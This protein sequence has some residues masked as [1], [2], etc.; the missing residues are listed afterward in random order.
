MAFTALFL[1]HTCHVP[2]E[3]LFESSVQTELHFLRCAGQQTTVYLP[4][5]QFVPVKRARVD[6]NAAPLDPSKARQF[7][8][9]LSRFEFN[10]LPNPHYKA[11]RF[12][13]KVCIWPSLVCAHASSLYGR[14]T[15]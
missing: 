1:W 12:S 8:L 2:L 15:P 6:P 10:G 4:W 13:L 3:V 5:R 11:G 9:V 7:G 14:H